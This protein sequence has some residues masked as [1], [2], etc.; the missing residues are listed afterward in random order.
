METPSGEYVVCLEATVKSLDLTLEIRK[1]PLRRGRISTARPQG[2]E[3]RVGQ[4]QRGARRTWYGWHVGG[5]NQLLEL[6]GDLSCS[7][8]AVHF[9]PLTIFHFNSRYCGASTSLLA[10]SWL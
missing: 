1:N 8:A 9:F 3:L 10:G 7:V 6:A 4:P 2:P 5:H